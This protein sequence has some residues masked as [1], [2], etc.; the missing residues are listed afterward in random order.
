MRVFPTSKFRTSTFPSACVVAV[1]VLV[2]TLSTPL[3]PRVAGAQ[4]AAT[5]TTVASATTTVGGAST[6]TTVA[7]ATTVVGGASTP[8]AP[9]SPTATDVS[10]ATSVAPVK[11]GR[12]GATFTVY[13]SPSTAKPLAKLTNLKNVF[14]RVVFIVLEDQ[15]DWLKV[16]APIRQNGGVG[17]VQA[18]II[19]RRFLHDWRIK[20]EIGKRQL[21]L[22]R[23]AEVIMTEKVVVG[24][25]KTP[26]PT[27]KF[28]TVDIV[29]PKT[30]NGPYGAFAYGI[31]GFSPV[32]QKFGAGDGRI[33]IHGTNDPSKLGT[34]A[35]NGCIRISNAAVTKMRNMLPLGVPVEIVA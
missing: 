21:T 35:S 12:R 28:Y 13:A 17:Y 4:E 25:A 16:S 18:S 8:S 23:G 11:D 22:T 1:T 33:G 31:S 27:G 15:G 9:V 20:V 19:D 29:K 10:S 34:A 7:S 6:P 3:A 2:A 30:P 24:L 32:Y 26:T 14:G 5:T